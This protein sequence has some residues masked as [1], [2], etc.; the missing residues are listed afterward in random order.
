VR[1]HRVTYLPS[2]T[3]ATVPAG[4]SV[5]DAAHWAGLPIES[6]CGGR[7]TCGTCRVRVL[8]GASEP[9]PADHR[10]L[11]DGL[12]AG[13]R[14]A[15]RC[16][17]ASDLVVEV[18]R[19]QRTPRAATM[20][21]GRVV[22]LEPNVRA[23]RL[24]LAPPSLDD[25]RSHLARVRDALAA[26][27]GL[28]VTVEPTVLAELEVAIG[29]RAGAVTT[30]VVG[31]R[32]V[33][34]VPEG[35]RARTFGV[36]IDLGTTTVVATLVD[37][38]TGVVAA[39]AT[40]INHQAVHGADVIARMGYAMAE[41]DG[42]DRLRSEALETIDL[43]IARVLAEADVRPDEVY[44]AIVVGNAA[45]LHLL[46]GAHPR[47][48]A[49]APFVA[50]FLEP[51]DLAARDLGVRIHPA[52]RVVLLPSLGAY[53]GAD[54]VADVLATG[55][56]R[57]PERTLLVDVG[58]NGEIVCGNV[59][60]AAATAAPAGP[61]FEGGQILHGMRA[62]EGAIEGVDLTGG[63]VT[64]QVIGD[65]RPTG[66]CGSGLID[67]VA[68]LRLV[69][70]LDERGGLLSREEALATRH[71]LADHLVEAR[72]VRAFELAPGVV[73]TQLDIRE[74][75]SAKG[76]IA[77]GIEVVLDVLGLGPHELDRI[78]LAGSFGTY[79]HPE[80]ARIIGLVP[81]VPVQRISAV[82]NA[83]SEGAKM[84]LL[85]FREREVASQLPA[86]IGYVELSGRTDFNER[87]LRNLAFPRLPLAQAPA[88]EVAS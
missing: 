62:T 34:V 59:E 85:S 22:L 4:T 41:A 53:V 19:L 40:E 43:V 79:I 11:A 32:L 55:L 61:A 78:L 63:R 35:E 17:V 48:I 57:G 81:P 18:P 31:D 21:V 64:L 1:R 76:A 77:T 2:G 33:R 72:G 7:G 66:I 49:V 82:G 83:A 60:R 46:V 44:E 74:L 15:C 67:A 16:V 24:D 14:L 42:L 39:V 37:L 70:L 6:T 86:R 27:P 36:A 28:E 10:H 26:G 68:Q 75:Q 29:E 47:S 23:H 13:W 12:A 25:P 56:A 69:G 80:S 3:V 88:A 73:L 54:I 65:V 45:M 71:P 52:G 87:F 84:A 51:Q 8:E 9:T 20:G 30:V 5:F 50:S 58:T 38:A